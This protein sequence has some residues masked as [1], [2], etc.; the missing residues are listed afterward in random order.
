M[1]EFPPL[2]S[3]HL[4]TRASINK[5]QLKKRPHFLRVVMW[6]NLLHQSIQIG[7]K[8]CTSQTGENNVSKRRHRRYRLSRNGAKPHFKYERPRI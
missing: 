6:Y 8:T 1:V 2:D 3:A 5:K 4:P 7:T